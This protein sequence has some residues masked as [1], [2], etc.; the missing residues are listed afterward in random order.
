MPENIS[1]DNVLALARAGYSKDE[2]A[3]MLTAAPEPA[4]APDPAPA[5]APA[6]VPAPAPAPAPAPDPAPAAQDGIQQRLDQVLEELRA[7]AIRQTVQPHQETPDEILAQII[8]PKRR[9]A[10]GQP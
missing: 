5:P 2:I 7:A 6:P 3:A 4:P 10:N 9:D 8:R 1:L